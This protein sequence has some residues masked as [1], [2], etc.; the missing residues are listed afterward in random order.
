MTAQKQTFEALFSDL[1]RELKHKR[2]E[3][4]VTF[5]IS[6]LPLI[7]VMLCN[8]S[9]GLSCDGRENPIAKLLDV[10]L[11]ILGVDIAALAIIMALFQNTKLDDKAKEAFKV[12]SIAFIGNAIVQLL[13]I[14]IAIM[15]FACLSSLWMA[16]YFVFLFQIWALLLVFDIILELFSL[17]TAIT[18]K[19]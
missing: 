6:L 11:S 7:I 10:N 17:R 1:C 3:A 13:S 14:L 16:S 8:G 15:Y 9:I 18:N 12:Q 5:V 4:I 19:H 2:C